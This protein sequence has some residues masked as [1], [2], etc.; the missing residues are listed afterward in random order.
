MV[1]RGQQSIPTAS[2][3][4]VASRSAQNR[5]NRALSHKLWAKFTSTKLFF[6]LWLRRIVAV[7]PSYFII[8]H[9]GLQRKIRCFLSKWSVL[10]CSKRC[11]ARF[12]RFWEPQ[13]ASTIS[14]SFWDLSSWYL[15]T[16]DWKHPRSERTFHCRPPKIMF[17]KWNV[18]KV[19][20]TFQ[21][22]PSGTTSMIMAGRA[23]VMD[24][25][26]MF[27]TC[28]EISSCQI[29]LTLSRNFAYQKSLPPPSVAPARIELS[30][31]PKERVSV[32][33]SL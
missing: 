29:G 4:W 28:T 1:F 9:H 32:S 2:K 12:A 5:R 17:Q 20:V 16:Y 22:Q 25:A 14:A 33:Y 30:Q 31:P 23:E 7:F 21:I 27:F 13:T 3:F 19:V 26:P 10:P 6:S 18:S 15:R 11:E 24:R 8:S